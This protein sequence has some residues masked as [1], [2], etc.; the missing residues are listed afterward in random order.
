[1]KWVDDI[2]GDKIDDRQFGGLCGT[3]TAD[4]LVELTHNNLCGM[5]QLTN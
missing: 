2:V 1:M 3:S 4:A 5:K